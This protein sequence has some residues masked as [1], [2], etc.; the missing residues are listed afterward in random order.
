MW[1]HR[2]IDRERE[3]ERE[4]NVSVLCG[5]IGEKVSIYRWLGIY[6]FQ[7]EKERERESIIWHQRCELI[8]T[9]GFLSIRL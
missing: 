6:I 7:R 9:Y 3:I 2:E 8:N 1:L 4:I 5:C